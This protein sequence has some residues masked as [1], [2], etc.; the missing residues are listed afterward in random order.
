M[1][2]DDKRTELQSWTVE[3]LPY[4]TRDDGKFQPDFMDGD[5]VDMQALH[6]EIW[7]TDYYVIGRHKAQKWLGEDTF[8]VIDIV[9]QYEEDMF[10]LVTTD[11]SEP[12]HI[13]NMYAY[14]VGEE[15]LPELVDK[16]LSLLQL[17]KE[18]QPYKDPYDLHGWKV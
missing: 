9:K 5:E 3:C 7:N 10:G 1:S 6:H 17:K 13:V 16:Y 15:I 2:I 4:Y 8:T 12:E 14:I 11:L 18:S